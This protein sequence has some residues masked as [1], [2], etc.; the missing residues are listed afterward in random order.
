MTHI[1]DV[2]ENALILLTNLTLAEA[3]Q[4]LENVIVA[5]ADL[6]VDQGSQVVSEKLIRYAVDQNRSNPK[7]WPSPILG[8]S[9]A[10]HY[11]AFVLVEIH[12]RLGQVQIDPDAPR[13]ERVKTSTNTAL[14]DE[15][16]VVQQTST[17]LDKLPVPMALDWFVA[18]V[19]EW[20]LTY[21]R[22]ALLKTLVAAGVSLKGWTEMHFRHYPLIV[23]QKRIE[24]P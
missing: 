12:N 13:I 11:W 1:D 20:S 10:E 5:W 21:D 3:S 15:I 2:M 14:V 17:Y 4:V 19:K 6:L 7:I 22:S 18:L 23:L 16:S 24:P 9:Q 8:K